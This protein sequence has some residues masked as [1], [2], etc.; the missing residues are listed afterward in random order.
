MPRTSILTAIRRRAARLAGRQ[1]RHPGDES[2]GGSS[3]NGPVGDR[4]RQAGAY[5]RDAEQDPRRGEAHQP[6]E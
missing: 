4:E 6:A 3:V 5:G 1:D 2:P